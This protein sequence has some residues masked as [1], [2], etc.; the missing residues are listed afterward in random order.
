MF[1]TYLRRELRR[2]MRQASLIVVGLALGIGLVITVTALSAGVKNA[3]GQVLHSLY[4]VG[5]D[6]TVTKA[7]AASTGGPPSFGFRG[8][9]G[10]RTRPA[11]GTTIDIDNLASRGTGTL[12]ASSVTTVAHLRNVAA[13][14]GDLVLTD[15]KIT[16]KI[17]AIN[18]SGGGGGFGGGGGGGFSGAFTPSS[19]SVSG[20]DLNQ[21]ALGPL[22]SSKLTSGRTLASSDATAN[23]AVIDSNYATQN[24]LKVGSTVTVAKT[25]FK[26]VG[27]VSTPA[28]SDSSDV[29]LPLA[30]AQALASMKNDVN[31]IY[32]AASSASDITTVS[33]E[34]SKAVPSA[35]VTN[36]SDLAKELTGS[37]S[38][39]SNLANNLGRWLAIAVLI[40]AFLLAS[41]LTMAAVARRVREFG[42]LKALGWRSRR[43]IGQVVGE[44]V[45]IGIAGGVIGIGLGYLGA[46]LVGHLSKP[47]TASLGQTTGSA[48]PGG[49]RTFGGAG[50]GGGGFGGGGGG[51]FAG[52]FARAAG[53]ATHTVSVHLTAPVTAEIVIVAVLLA[54]AGGLIAGAFG[55]WRAARLRPAAAL[56]R[57]E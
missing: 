21:G 38:S 54:I 35:T 42:T 8:Q 17:P 33:K 15:T 22:S 11:A 16:G 3:Q 50:R 46:G 5:T 34:I 6:I 20:I 28:G 29:Y 23:V 37:I 14:A 2:R 13:V 39:T 31:T 41:L 52:R 32:V 10:T 48:T 30:R 9:T 7:A 53:N 1:L 24:K 27:V 19:F 4:G 51:N 55:G 40:A 45:V 18:S 26:V 25:A 43:V 44:A 56:A 36:S 12:A 49:A 57:V 47:L